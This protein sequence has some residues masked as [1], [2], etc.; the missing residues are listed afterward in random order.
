MGIRLRKAFPAALV[1][2]LF[3]LP[4]SARAAEPPPAPAGSYEQRA[5]AEKAS[6]SRYRDLEVASLVLILVGGGAAIIWALKRK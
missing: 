2:L 5:A 3:L 6:R 1:L 4:P